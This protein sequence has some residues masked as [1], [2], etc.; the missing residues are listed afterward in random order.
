VHDLTASPSD[1]KGLAEED[2][3]MRMAMA[4]SL[5]DQI[6]SQEQCIDKVSAVAS[7]SPYK[8]S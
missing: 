7:M 5:Q 3:D 8:A 6:K 4:M 2:A 1:S